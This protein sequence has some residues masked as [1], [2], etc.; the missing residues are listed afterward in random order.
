MFGDFIYWDFNAV[1][2]DIFLFEGK[3]YVEPEFFSSPQAFNLKA[4]EKKRLM[5]AMRQ[6]SKKTQTPLDTSVLGMFDR[7]KEKTDS[8]KTEKN[9][10]KAV[11]AAAIK[12]KSR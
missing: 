11:V 8:V 10:K 5:T 6:Y 1:D 2:A 4:T 3:P 12:Q 7:K 9:T